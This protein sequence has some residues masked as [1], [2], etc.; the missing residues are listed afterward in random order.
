[1]TEDKKV[2][3]DG[4]SIGLA[5]NSISYSRS[6]RETA[7]PDKVLEEEGMKMAEEVVR[8]IRAKEGLSDIR[9]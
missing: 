3:L 2:R 5:L 8:R 4:I 7:I 6:G 1:M 9:L